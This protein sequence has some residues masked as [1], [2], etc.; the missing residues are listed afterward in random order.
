M[1]DLEII[2]ESLG[3]QNELI[4]DDDL[5]N[6]LDEIDSIDDNTELFELAKIS[7][8]E[9][10]PQIF[11]Y[12]MDEC[13]FTKNEILILVNEI[14]KFKSDQAKYWIED[15]DDENAI[16]SIVAAYE[17]IIKFNKSNK[18]PYRK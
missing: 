12:L 13:K 10:K 2:I 16:D 8:K 18:L 3:E 17:K 14:N 5:E 1:G 4:D 15:T 6:I 9:G 11:K 7:I